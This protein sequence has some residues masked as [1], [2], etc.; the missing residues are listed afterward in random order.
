MIAHLRTYT[1]NKG[2]MEPWLKLFETE[3]EPRMA[4]L[5]LSVHSRWVNDARSQFIWI[6]V[7]GET[8]ADL[9]TKE[10]ALYESAWWVANVDMVRGHIAHRDIVLLHSVSTDPAQALTV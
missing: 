6:R 4:A 9:Q 10:K 1:I 2:M 8:E 7:Y 3:L 5:G